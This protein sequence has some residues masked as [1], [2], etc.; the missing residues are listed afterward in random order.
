M[1]ILHNLAVLEGS[2]AVVTYMVVCTFGVVL[3]DSAGYTVI[4]MVESMTRGPK[5]A[6]PVLGVQFRNCQHMFYTLPWA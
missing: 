1:V 4:A 3:E 6:K 2:Q 5:Q